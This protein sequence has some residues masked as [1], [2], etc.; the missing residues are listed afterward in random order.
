MP[1]APHPENEAQRL[2]SLRALGILDTAPEERF[3]RLTRI[4]RRFF[5]VPI[6]LVSLVD[7]DRVW[8]KSRQ[9]ME[10]PEVPR[11]Y[12]FC[13][14]AL[15]NGEPVLVV[16]DAKADERFQTNPLVLGSPEIRFYAASR[17]RGPDGSL[18][19]TLCVIDHR[20]R[21]VDQDD[22]NVLRDLAELVERELKSLSLATTDDLT[23]LSNRRGFEA[24]AAHTLA[25]CLR[26]E[27][28]ATLLL[29]DLDEFKTVNDTLG[30]A[31]GD[32]LL[33]RFAGH[34]QSTF[35]DSD[36]V[37][38]LGGDEF[39]VLLSGT[40]VPDVARPI[41]AL[42]EL[43]EDAEAPVAAP[44]SVGAV[45]YDPERHGSLADLLVDADNDMYANKRSG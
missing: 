26:V 39:C 29:F 34:L 30:H 31:A 45:A 43:M 23:G 38:R 37:A 44:F 5:R 17:V 35:R 9:G 18:L 13:A 7:A 41:S 32:E 40:A 19:G 11:E 25:V 2:Q 14:H 24:I 3:D 6:A 16:P 20:P 1:P 42:R 27:R 12:S 10:E 28:P 21:E 4:A 8:F 33:K 22:A 15:V 36:V